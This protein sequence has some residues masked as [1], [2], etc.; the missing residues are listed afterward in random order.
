MIASK[1]SGFSP[2]THMSSPCLTMFSFIL[3]HL[4]NKKQRFSETASSGSVICTGQVC[5]IPSLPVETCGSESWL[6][7]VG[8]G[9]LDHSFAVGQQV[10]V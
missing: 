10:L 3:M 2:L 1:P 7:V 6:H 4:V 5:Q 8:A 9:G